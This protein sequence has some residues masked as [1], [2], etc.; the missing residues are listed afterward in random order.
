MWRSN[1]GG[2]RYTC[3]YIRIYMPLL[4]IYEQHRRV[5]VRM[6]ARSREK[7]GFKGMFFSQWVAELA[8]LKVLGK[9]AHLFF[10]NR[11]SFKPFR[12]FRLLNFNSRLYGKVVV[13]CDGE[14]RTITF[15][16]AITCICKFYAITVY[17]NLIVESFHWKSTFFTILEL[18]QRNRKLHIF[19]S[20]IDIVTAQ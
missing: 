7:D 17:E 11:L 3:A 9:R 4:C 12:S 15:L 6:R 10:S 8:T 14:I 19:I 16:I 2:S 18:L 5:Y 13:R 1:F 20:Y